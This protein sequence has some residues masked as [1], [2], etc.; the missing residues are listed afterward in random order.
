MAMDPAGRNHNAPTTGDHDA[1]VHTPMLASYRQPST[2]PLAD[3]LLDKQ[4]EQQSAK[5][6][7]PSLW[8]RPKTDDEGQPAAKQ[9]PVDW[10]SVRRT[11]KA[12]L[13]NPMNVALL[14]W[15][16]CVGVSGGMLVLLLLGLLDGAFPETASR[17]GGSRRTT[18]C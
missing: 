13:K 3:H 16:L 10:P 7:L 14:L 1:A 17:N 5:Y 18:R 2:A 11:C 12:W 4:P 8:C 15:L 6:W 9:V